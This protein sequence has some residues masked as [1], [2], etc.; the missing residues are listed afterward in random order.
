MIV[1]DRREWKMGKQEAAN[2][3]QANWEPPFT[4]F[5][6]PVFGFLFAIPV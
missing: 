6:F 3:R 4:G 5:E 2:W 1:R